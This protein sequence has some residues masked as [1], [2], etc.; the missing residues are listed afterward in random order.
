M[1]QVG[2]LLSISDNSG[3]K[4]SKMHQNPEKNKKKH[5]SGR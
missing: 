2:T 5:G 3:A 1:I 4:K